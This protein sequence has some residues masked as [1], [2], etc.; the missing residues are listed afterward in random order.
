MHEAQ[1]YFGNLLEEPLAENADLCLTV[2]EELLQL[3]H[4][5]EVWE[6]AVKAM[7]RNA[8]RVWVQIVHPLCH[9]TQHICCAYAPWPV[10]SCRLQSV[11]RVMNPV[12]ISYVCSSSMQHS[13][14]SCV[15]LVLQEVM[16]IIMQ[17]LIFYKHVQELPDYNNTELWGK[18]AEC[19]QALGNSQELVSMYEAVMQD[20]LC[21]AWKQNEA[22]LALA[23]LHL[24][25]GATLAAQQVLSILKQPNEALD[26]TEQQDG[27][28]GQQAQTLFHR[29]GLMLR[30]GQQVSHSCP[31]VIAS[32]NAAAACAIAETVCGSS[33][34]L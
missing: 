29:A 22:A 14:C 19:Q 25:A 21:P 5:E 16:F 34:F 8:V 18:I 2:A 11:M 23:Q 1:Q 15:Y 31:R 4:A 7:F 17:A 10:L 24:D 33:K 28:A 3:Q 9:M 27:S 32:A 12:H 26:D 30:L 20:Q 13:F 6:V